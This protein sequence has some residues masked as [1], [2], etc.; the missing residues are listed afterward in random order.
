MNRW[1]LNFRG[2]NPDEE[3][4]REALCTLGNGYFATR[5]ATAESVADGIHYPGTYL[6][7][8]YNRLSTE[9]SG[10]IVENEDLV[11]FPNWLPL[12]FRIE[13][14]EWFDPLKVELL[15][16]S[17][18]LDLKRGILSRIIRFR[19]KQDRITRVFLRRFVSMAAHH[20]A[21]LE[22]ALTTENWSGKIDI[23]TA[24]DGNVV[25]SGV[26]RYGRLNNQHLEPVETGVIGEDGILLRVKT[27]QS[28]I[29]VAQAAKTQVFRDDIKLAPQRRNL[30][31]LGY[32]AQDLTLHMQKKQ[33][34]TIEKILCF[35]TSR[36]MAIS[37]CSRYAQKHLARTS[38]FERLMQKHVRRWEHLWRRFDMEIVCSGRLGENERTAMILHLHIFHLLQTIS[39]HSIDVDVG[40]PARGWHGE[41]Y[42]GHIFWDEL[43]IFPFLNLRLPQITRSLL[44]YRYH[45][46]RE[47]RAAARQAGFRGAMYPWQSGSSGR[48]ESQQIHLNPRS[49]RWKP[50]NSRLQRHVNSAIAYNIWRYYEATSDIEFLGFYGAEMFL[51]IARFWASVAVYN[52]EWNRYEIRGVMGPDEYHD[53]YPGAEKPGVDNNAYTNVMA[54]WVLCRALIILE[55]L[56]E[57]R[58]IELCE[59]LEIS[60][61]EIALW[62]DISRNMRIVFHGNGIISQFE[63][64]E[65]LEEFDWQKYRSKYGNIQRLDRILE[66]EGD[67]PNRYKLS[68][69]ADVLMLFYLFSWH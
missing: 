56:P 3:G 36:D 60:D 30:E 17:Q 13:G 4:L 35:Y 19:D 5:G 26:R 39:I 16:Y 28:Q 59:A 44:K 69:Q 43:F 63:G 6:A 58:R 67:T 52:A 33:K 25:N 7:C 37:D 45:R 40:I 62:N 2:F 46:L 42:R 49:G 48:E 50:D 8:G 65:E 11:N 32:I 21:A 15:E 41:A 10:R 14:G 20:I 47:A 12:T 53:A 66:K 29:Q 18:E 22:M 57:D 51:E 38:R 61:E 64:Y 24:L 23:R 27:N 1:T 55:I 9:I 31:R 68:K 54:A 34:V